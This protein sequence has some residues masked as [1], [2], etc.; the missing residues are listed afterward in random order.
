MWFVW[1]YTNISVDLIFL[2]FIF[3]FKKSPE[4]TS[5]FDRK[6]L[7]TKIDFRLIGA[8]YIKNR[9]V[10]RERYKHFNKNDELVFDEKNDWLWI[11]LTTN[12]Q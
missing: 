9:S 6:H 2:W 11:S 5:H 3:L 8:E 12:K 10:E 1:L 4:D 7:A